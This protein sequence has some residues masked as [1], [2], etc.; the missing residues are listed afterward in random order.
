MIFFTELPFSALRNSVRGVDPLI[1]LALIC[2]GLGICFVVL[3]AELE[4][5]RARWRE[6]S[7]KRRSLPA[8]R[9]VPFRWPLDRED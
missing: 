3:L 9:P 1:F 2:L 5:S 8:S 4:K 7:M 6:N